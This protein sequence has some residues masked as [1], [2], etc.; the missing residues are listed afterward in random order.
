MNELEGRLPMPQFQTTGSKQM[1]RWVALA[2]NLARPW[3]VWRQL[4]TDALN[5]RTFGFLCHKLADG[6]TALAEL[7]ER[8][9]TPSVIVDAIGAHYELRE[10]LRLR[11]YRWNQTEKVWSRQVAQQN[12][13][14]E[15]YRLDRHVYGS[16]HRSTRPGPR[17]REVDA[18][19]R[20]A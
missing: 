10:A 12:L 9:G 20:Y 16:R 1:N 11:G 13:E 6:R 8:S 15:E 19:T 5:R 3:L 14:Q 17:L 7:T 2:R 4:S 18:R